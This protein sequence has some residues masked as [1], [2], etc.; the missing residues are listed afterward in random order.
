VAFADTYSILSVSIHKR[1]L[2]ISFQ[3]HIQM[4]ISSSFDV[5]LRLLSD[6][7]VTFNY[8]SLIISA[9]Q[10]S[11]YKRVIINSTSYKLRHGVY[12]LILKSLIRN[13]ILWK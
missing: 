5:I 11:A 12:I 1:K 6:S 9:R 4:Q 8:F 2:S 3:V 7:H 13:K 10:I